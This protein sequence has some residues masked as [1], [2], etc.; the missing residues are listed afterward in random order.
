[1]KRPFYFAFFV[2]FL[3]FAKP[4]CSG[5]AAVGVPLAI[6]VGSNNS[7]NVIVSWPFPSTGFGIEFSTNLGVASWAAATNKPATNNSRWAM[8]AAATLPIAYFRLK[9]HL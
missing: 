5:Q 1:M 8:S 7:S 2:L 4:S 9:N 6:G 3:I